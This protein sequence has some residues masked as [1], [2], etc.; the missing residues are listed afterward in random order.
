MTRNIYQ[1]MPLYK[2]GI[3]Q[4]RAARNILEFRE[5]ILKGYG[6]SASEWYVLGYVRSQTRKGGVRV[7]DIATMLD[8][9][10]TYITGIL[11]R[12]EAKELVRW[13]TDKTDRRARIITTTKKGTAVCTAVETELLKQDETWLGKTSDAAM[14]GYL[15]VMETLA[16]ME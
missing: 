9:Q 13:V 11:R 16:H 1:D 3:I 7:G 4:S 5:G 10:S 2:I 8:V 15:S 12:L 14:R 6:L